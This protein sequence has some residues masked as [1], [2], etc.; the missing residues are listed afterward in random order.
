[1]MFGNP[2]PGLGQTYKC[3]SIKPV[4]G[5]PMYHLKKI[6]LEK[7]TSCAT[8]TKLAT[9]ISVSW[10]ID[11]VFFLTNI[12]HKRFAVGHLRHRAAYTCFSYIY[13]WKKILQH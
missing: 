9:F 5:I 13:N 3:G 7:N 12:P 11:L 2:G 4:I 6:N 10:Y 8:G 1:M